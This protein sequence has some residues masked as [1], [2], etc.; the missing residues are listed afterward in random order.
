[1]HDAGLRHKQVPRRGDAVGPGAGAEAQTDIEDVGYRN[2]I[3]IA[4]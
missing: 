4:V 2:G 3:L 1:M